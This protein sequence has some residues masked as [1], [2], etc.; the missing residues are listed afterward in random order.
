MVTCALEEWGVRMQDIKLTN[1]VTQGEPRCGGGYNDHD[2]ARVVVHRLVL[3][4]RM[5]RMAVIT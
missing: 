3:T 2:W 4:N 1:R 5:S